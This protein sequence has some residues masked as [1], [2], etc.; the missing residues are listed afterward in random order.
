MRR[1][2][3]A[4]RHLAVVSAAPDALDRFEALP[5]I[6]AI[7]ERDGP[8]SCGLTVEGV[9]VELAVTPPERL[10]TA[11]LRATGSAAYVAALGPLPDAPTEAAVYRA[12]GLPWLPPELR[13]APFAGEPPPLLTE[14][15][16]R[17]DLHTHTTWSDGRFSVEEMGRAAR[18]RGYD[19]LAICDHTPAV[20]AVRGLS[21][22]TS[23]ARVR[24]S[25]PPTRRSRR[26]ASCAGS[27]ATSCPTAGS[28]FPTTCS[29]SSTG[30]RPAS[31]AASGCHAPT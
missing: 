30:S 14:Q 22:A 26:S 19:Y 15:D 12:L 11:L 13:E 27:S 1:W 21:P 3:D 6:V 17:G 9:P 25:P 24:R 16:I 20:G 4:P 31:T 10:G 8:R 18:D 2:R 7:I 5:Q 28:T 29:P 23:A